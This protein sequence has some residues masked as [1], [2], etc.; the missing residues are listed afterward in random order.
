MQTRRRFIFAGSVFAAAAFA[1]FNQRRVLGATGKGSGT[2]DESFEVVH[3]DDQWRR[4]LTPAQYNVL[5]A[6]R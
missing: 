2:A 4:L 3:P 6:A 5:I 1:A